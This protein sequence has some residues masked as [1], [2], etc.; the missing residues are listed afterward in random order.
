MNQTFPFY[1][2]S[3]FQ[4]FSQEKK[5]VFDNINHKL[6]DGVS[7]W[8]VLRDEVLQRADTW[9]AAVEDLDLSKL[10]FLGVK[11]PHML[12]IEARKKG[13]GVVQGT[14]F[15]TLFYGRQWTYWLNGLTFLV[16]HY[17]VYTNSMAGSQSQV[18]SS[19]G[20]D[21]RMGDLPSQDSAKLKAELRRYVSNE[22][23][24]IVEQIYKDPLSMNYVLHNFHGLAAH[25]DEISSSLSAL[26]SATR[27]V[28]FIFFFFQK[29]K[30]EKITL[31][32]IQ[33]TTTTNKNRPPAM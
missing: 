19:G 33:T 1:V 12:V 23:F 30:R 15:V 31:F 21:S 18:L 16:H 9:E 24:G 2:F 8:S 5:G 26:G 29:K 4:S 22:F 13:S 14:L 6:L 3:T 11:S 28:L 27:Q 25:L 7:D 32:E 20:G 10:A 17:F